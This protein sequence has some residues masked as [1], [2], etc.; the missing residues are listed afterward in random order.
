MQKTNKGYLIRHSSGAYLGSPRVN[1]EWA[2]IW[3]TL[4]AWAHIYP[5]KKAAKQDAR[6]GETIEAYNDGARP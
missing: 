3:T 1:P 4:R 2:D 5:T 6:K